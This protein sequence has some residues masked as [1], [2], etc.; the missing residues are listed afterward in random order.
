ME[1]TVVIYKSKYGA[2]KQ[3]ATW[4]SEELHCDLLNAD[5]V[6]PKDLLEYENIIFGGGIHAGGITGLSLIK[7]NYKKLMDK[8]VVIFAVGINTEEEKNM[9]DLRD[10]NFNGKIKDLPCFL[11]KGAYDPRKVK[12]LDNFLMTQV[13]KMIMKKPIVQR[14]DQEK[15]LVKVIDYG[16]DW[17]EK[18]N[19]AP[20]IAAIKE[21]NAK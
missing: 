4:I 3:Y 1:N 20:I 11:I 16:G 15:A 14:T 10:I 6:K 7:K 8:K 2:T 18:E 21:E 12:G 9:E 5:E 13:R 17:V 19:L